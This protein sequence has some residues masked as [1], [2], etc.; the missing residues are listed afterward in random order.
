MTLVD[1]DIPRSGYS[2]RSATPVDELALHMLLPDVSD[3]ALS[4]VASEGRRGL[5]VGGAILTRQPR[6]R[7]L[8]GPGVAVHVIKPCRQ[9]GI[10]SALIDALAGLAQASGAR[11][12]YATKRVELHSHEMEQWQWLG[13]SVCETVCEHVLP[14]AEFEPKLGP[15]LE[16]MRGQ[17]RI[18]SGSTI[19]PLYRA[20]L[21]AVLNLHLSHM[22]G[23]RD[24]L[25]RKLRGEGPGAFHP[26]YSR[27]L[28]VDGVVR[29]CILAHRG[30]QDTAIVDANI[31]DPSVRG[32]WANVWLKLESTRGALSLG[33]KNFQFTTF[34]Q[35]TDTRRFTQRFGGRTVRTSVLMYRVL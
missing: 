26:R 28:L 15:L 4:M 3:I 25:S 23:V 22:G 10:A 17:G 5:V 19:V 8:V 6:L 2:I 11:A 16:R 21:D 9:A 7:P 20:D 35:Y 1:F 24:D 34:D 18:P 31:L 33:I 32:G 14:L 13:F 27:V 12:L 30:D 29:G